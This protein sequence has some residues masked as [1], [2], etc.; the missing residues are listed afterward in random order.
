M[1]LAT[2]KGKQMKRRNQLL[3]ACLTAGIASISVQAAWAQT[4]HSGMSKPETQKRRR[5][6]LQNQITQTCRG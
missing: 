6:P 2:T 5:K 4:G 3:A 1:N